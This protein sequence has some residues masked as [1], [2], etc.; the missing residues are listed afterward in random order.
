MTLP[1]AVCEGVE[2]AIAE[3]GLGR[4][5]Q[6][7]APV[8]GGCINNGARLQIDSGASL[9]LKWNRASPAGMFEAEADGL[10]ALGSG[11]LRVPE[12]LAWNDHGTGLAWLLMDH[13]PFGPSTTQSQRALG[14][15][16][17]KLHA[18][19]NAATFGWERD[20]WIGSLEQKNDRG[21][22]WGDFWRDRRIAPQLEL[23][24]KHGFARH[25]SF[26]RVLEAIPGGLADV[27]RPDLLHG[28]L[29]GG[30][31]FTS[32]DGEPVLIDPA[33]Y[34]GHGEVDLAMSEL[35]GGFGPAF[36]EAYEEVRPLSS[37][38]SAYRKALYQLYYL[39][40]HV[41]LFGAA[42]ESGSR[43]AAESVLA[44]LGG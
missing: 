12:P 35:F 17:A 22:S 26:D 1:N 18:S 41:N 2:R 25:A 43:R 19:A 33:V 44:E 39:L 32:T 29:W 42:Y 4:R 6:A 36:Y 37:A 30:N 9:F 10:R 8:G 14:S 21:A 11:P 31:W 34:R 5:V 40:V 15:G 28:D 38:Y 16:L 3:H 27:E 23:A 13:I 24:R 20:N 7:V